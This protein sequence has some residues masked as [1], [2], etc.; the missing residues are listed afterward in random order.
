[1]EKS[2][3]KSVISNLQI[4]QTIGVN[5]LTQEENLNGNY[6]VLATKKGR[7]KGGSMMVELK[8]ND[9]TTMVLSTKDSERILN[10]VINDEFFGYAN[11]SDIPPVYEKN[12]D[13]AKEFKTAFES[14]IKASHLNPKE[15]KISS[16]VPELDGTH[17][18]VNSRRLR[19]RS[20]QIVLTTT[21][22]LEIW[23]YRH[24]GVID[25]F[26]VL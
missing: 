23:S 12:A 15:V 11:E 20:G 7:G 24:S 3:L 18:I 25:T 26:E 19:G 8:S 10:V 22:G 21:T 16:S 14:L 5:F 1:M 17:T 9:E 4:G 2:I 6:S 13:R